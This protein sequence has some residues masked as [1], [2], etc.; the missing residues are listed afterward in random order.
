MKYYKLLC[1]GILGFSTSVMSVSNDISLDKTAQLTS[2]N[3]NEISEQKLVT[4]NK[5]QYRVIGD[6]LVANDF[7]TNQFDSTK[8]KWT[9][10]IVYYQFNANVTIEN[11][12]RFLDAAKVWEDAADIQFIERTTQENFIHVQDDNRNYAI[13]GMVGGQQVVAVSNWGSKYIIVHELGHSLGMWHEQQRTDRDNYITILEDNI[14]PAQLYNFTKRTTTSYSDYDFMSIMHYP[15][16]A[17]TKNGLQTMSPKAG[18]EEIAQQAGQRSYISGGDQ[19][20]VAQHYGAKKINFDDSNFEQYLVANFDTNGDGNIDTLEA[21]NVTHIQTPGNGS[22]SSI[23]GIE[24]F[25]YLKTLNVSNENLTVLPALPSRIETIN[26]TNNQFSEFDESWSF[27]PL[28]KQIYASGNPLDPYFCERIDFLQQSLTN[29]EFVY[30]PMANGEDLICDETTQFLLINAKPRLELRS[31]G[32]QTYH[33]DVPA[34]QTA[35]TFTTSASVGLSGGEMDIYVAFGRQ[36]TVSDNDFSS[37]NNGNSELVEV[38]NPQAGTWFVTLAPTDRSYENVDLTAT[39]SDSVVDDKVLENGVTKSSLIAGKNE[40]LD[41]YIDIPTDAVNL[42]FSISGG[43]GDA[44]LYVRFANE[45][46]LSAYDCR[47]WKQGNIESCSFAQPQN[48]RYHVQ[49]VGYEAFSGVNLLASYEN[50]EP[51]NGDFSESSIQGN[52]G[53]WQHYAIEI[54]NG[55]SELQVNISGGTGDADLYLN[56]ANQSDL[57]NYIC[58]PYLTGNEEV[59]THENPQAGTWIISIYGYASYNNL[60][61]SAHWE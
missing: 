32:T 15:L 53:S 11:Q 23:A 45:P 41:F 14:E 61:L 44:D 5:R 2:E 7:S 33:I 59:C 28:I 49:L 48:G 46:T 43:T 54:P 35:L 8:N 26:V 60:T 56:Y 27:L 24:L 21:A 58:R 39:Y 6:M 22:I 19:L 10:G 29:G 1:L 47:P 12:Q 18:Y 13:V 42:K 57:S 37:T 25:R 38:Q 52:S 30:N 55:V 50:N 36:P 17:Y 34:G 9:D 3:L 51:V 31:K 20:G 4:Y 40:V 16:N